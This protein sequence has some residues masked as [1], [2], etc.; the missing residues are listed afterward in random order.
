MTSFGDP[1]H[2][3]TT[4]K[5]LTNKSLISLSLHICGDVQD[6]LA[7]AVSE[8]LA[9]QT[10]LNSFDLCLGGKLSSAG[11]SSL[12]KGLL[13]NSSLN[14]IKVVV[15]GELP[16]N[17]K[18]VVETLY[19]TK[20]SPVSCAF[21][22]N[23][24]DNIGRDDVGLVLAEKALV[25]KRHLTVNVWGKLS[26][27]GAD[28]LCEVLIRSPLAFNLLTLNVHG[29][30]TE[31]VASSFARCL[32]RC[33][34]PFLLSINIWGSLTPE[35]ERILSELSKSNR[36]VHLNVHHVQLASEKSNQVLDICI[37]NPA[38][39]RAFFTE[40][41]DSRK[42]KVSLTINNNSD[43]GE[44]TYHLADAFAEKI[45]LTF[46]N[47]TVNSCL[48]DCLLES[49]LQ[50][51]SIKFLSLTIDL[52]IMEGL[53][54]KLGT[55]FAKM[56]SLTTL[57]LRLNDYSDKTKYQKD[58]FNGNELKNVLV[59]IRSL[60]T[61]SVAV[62]DSSMVSFWNGVLGD[63]LRECT[64]LKNL[65][66]AGDPLGLDNG[67]TVTTSLKTLNITL[68]IDCHIWHIYNDSLAR[69]IEGLSLNGSLT[70]LTVTVSLFLMD[71]LQINILGDKTFKEGLSMNKF[72][73]T[74]NFTVNEFG[75]GVSDIDEI[76][77]ALEVFDGLAQN[78]S[79]T[80]FNL[81]LNSSREVRDDWLPGLCNA[82]NKNSSL[83]TLRLKVNNH[84]ATG[85]S[86]LYDLSKLLVESR[87]LSILELEVSFYAKGERGSK[88]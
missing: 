76:F 56:A 69:L 64:S 80:T 7:G 30:V 18:S 43:I 59:S 27:E 65:S 28:T 53:L 46:P 20:K 4:H 25:P 19:S 51:T 57:S 5:L 35:G 83:T 34:I 79:I 17:W 10:V 58:F 13:K 31:D 9:R 55:C 62:H 16:D 24:L 74:L 50:S 1:Q 15:C 85:E 78:T 3:E 86:R 88:F 45:S 81:T 41:K 70:T 38:A 82:V 42:E 29:N 54:C 68:N 2:Q 52:S 84:C 47:L 71:N 33:K 23:T 49:L 40:L 48:T 22:P 37:E 73:T 11:A 26:C 67:L 72:I 6:L 8:A 61:L 66:Y 87:S 36:C 77:R 21:Y 32:K 12:K 14:Y 63:C 39:L 60:S 44:W 75:E